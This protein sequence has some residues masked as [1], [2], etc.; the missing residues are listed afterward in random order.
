MDYG[1]NPIN[2]IDLVLEQSD[3]QDIAVSILKKLEDEKKKR[4]E[5]YNLIH[6]D[7]S[8]EFIHG[9]IVFHSPARYSHLEVSANVF[10]ILRSYV[11]NKQLGTVLIEKAMISLG[12]NDFEP[13]IVYFS[14]QKSNSFT[15]D[16]K[17]FPAPDIAV[18]ILSS[19]TEKNDRG[20]K[21]KEYALH[22]IAEYWI[23]DPEKKTFEQY[24]LEGKSYML[25][26]KVTN[27]GIILCNVLQ[28]LEITVGDL[29][30]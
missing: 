14:N 4:T 25:N 10:S 15:E 6:E 8:A 29:W 21:F 1:E 18:E 12:R 3:A 5:F 11:K 22:D 23:I 19:S 2:I 26:S 16:Q 13:D 7:I 9:E 30:A 24:I 27:K 20:V 17:L 28:G